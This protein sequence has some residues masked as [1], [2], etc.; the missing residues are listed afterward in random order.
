MTAWHV[1]QHPVSAVLLL[2]N[3][4]KGGE[5]LWVHDLVK[6]GTAAMHAELQA[7]IDGSSALIRS[8]A[9]EP[10]SLV[11]FRGWGGNK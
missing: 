8:M 6:Q 1:D 5:F 4:R 3:A 10:G 9:S 11:L 2:Q 7:I